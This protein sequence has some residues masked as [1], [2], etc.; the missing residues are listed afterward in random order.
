MDKLA[1]SSSKWILSAFT[2]S[3]YYLIV[4]YKLL[5][6]GIHGDGIEYAC[7]ARNMAEGW[8]TFWKPY[9]EDTLHPV[10]HEHPPLVY[11]IQSVFFR[12][13]GDGVH[14]EAFYGF[15]VGIIILLCSAL[16]WQQTRRDFQLRAVGIW[17]PMLLL[18]V[19]PMYGYLSQTNRMVFT[20]TVFATAATYV[21]Y[22][23]I[24]AGK[25]VVVLSL[26][27]GILVYLGFLSE[28][29]VA[30]FTFAVPACGW[31]CLNIK[32]SRAVVATLI[33]AVTFSILFVA[34]SYFF[35]DSLE[36]W[37]GF[38][39][40]QVIASLKSTRG[41]GDT[42]WYLP[43]RW[44]MEMIVPFMLVVIFK[45]VAGVPLR[46]LRFNHQAGFFLLVA[47]AGSLPFL[48]SKRQHARYIF[49][50]FPFYVLSLAFFADAV[51][52]KLEELLADRRS[53]R[54][55]AGALAVVFVV[56]GVASM[57]Y[58]RGT[59]DRR[60]E[61]YND[62]YLQNIRLPARIVVSVCPE[63]MIY[64]DWLFAT[65][66]RFYKVSLTGKMGHEYLIIDK[67]SNCR[68]PMNYQRVQQQPT[69]KYELYKRQGP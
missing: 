41:I 23:T 26:I 24:V 61:F 63:Q 37:K 52:V 39:Q 18:S 68:V 54:L 60:Q 47:A 16:F 1:K 30:W 43:E 33:T 35:P 49:Q 65:M 2:F 17:W 9:L 64:D 32:F 50:S 40:A 69:L 21:A 46:R 51:A 29:P 27:C 3:V 62:F 56:V 66:Q 36:F 31:L 12:L 45:I 8:G 53:F 58:Y 14:F 22:R 19:L 38:W 4:G 10:F 11:W 67:H 59:I 28:G 48:I 5:R 25:H 7:V 15:I 13:F 57:L 6:I 20:F 55:A 34:T 44:V 42:R